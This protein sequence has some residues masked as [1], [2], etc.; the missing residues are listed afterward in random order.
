MNLM[1]LLQVMGSEKKYYK[2]G[3][4]SAK[5]SEEY[6]RKHF[7]DHSKED[8]QAPVGSAIAPDKDKDELI[9]LKDELKG[10]SKL[11]QMEIS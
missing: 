8:E 4:M 2:R 10:K 6:M 3:D 5:M 7:G 1:L 9:K 11:L